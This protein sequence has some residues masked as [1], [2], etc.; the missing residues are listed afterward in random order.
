MGRS[1]PSAGA[2]RGLKGASFRARRSRSFVPGL[3]HLGLSLSCVLAVGCAPEF[4]KLE[5]RRSPRGTLGEEV[6][7]TLCRRVAGT[8]MPNDVEGRESEAICLGDAGAVA[9]ALDE[10]R[11]ALPKRVAVLAERREQFVRAVDAMLPEDTGDELEL[12]MR[13]LLPFYDAPEERVQENTRAFASVLERLAAN[14][15]ALNALTRV[16]RDGV[17]SREGSFGLYR[18]LLGYDRLN[19]LFLELLPVLSDDPNVRPYFQTML[20]GVAL[21]LA[22][23]DLDDAPDSDTRRL[24]A[25]MAREDNDF[26]SERPLFITLR[27]P[28]GLPV[29]TPREGKPVPF[30]FVDQDGD[31]LADVQDGDFVLDEGFKG[32]LPGAFATSSEQ[33]VSRDAFGRALGFLPDGS[34]ETV[35]TLFETRDID[36]T[37]LAGAFREMTALFD[38]KGKTAVHVARLVPAIFGDRTVQR[39]MY[40]KAQLDYPASDTEQSPVVDLMHASMSIFE[41]PAY[42]QSLELTHRMIDKHEAEMVHALSP[43]LRLEKRTRADSDAYPKASLAKDSVFWDELLFEAERMS[44]RRKTQDGPTL[45]ELL[46]RGA[47]GY[48]RNTSKPGAPVEQIVDPEV[49]R[50]QG[51]LIATLMRYKDEWRNNP[52]GESERDPSEPRTIGSFRTPVDRSLPDSPVTCGKD[53]CGGLIEGSPFERW[54]TPGQNCVLQ[55][56]GRPKSGKDCGAPA[57]QSVLHRSMGLIWEMAGRSQCNKSITLGDLL[58]FAVVQ[59]AC[60]KL[61]PAKT[62]DP[63]AANRDLECQGKY[64]DNADY[65]CDAATAL[66]IAKAGSDECIRLKQLQRVER[67]DTI[68]QAEERVAHDYECPKDKPGAAC[69]AYVDEFPAAFVDPDGPGVG[70]P[71]TLM[72][73]NLINLPD[74][75]RSFGRALTHEFTIEIPNPWMRRYLE[76]VARAGNESIPD[77]DDSFVITDPTL[78]PPCIPGSARLSRDVYDEMS[79]EIDTLGELIAYLLDDSSLFA[80][81]KDSEEL[82]PDVAALTRVLFAPPGSSSFLMFDP[83]LVHGSPSACVEDDPKPACLMDDTAKTPPGGCCIKNPTRP[84]FR[85]RLDTYYGTTSFAWEHPIEFDDGS[86]LSLIDAMKTLADGVN[87]TDYDAASGDDPKDFEGTDFLFSTLG[88]MVA[89]HYDSPRN[90]GVQNKDPALPHYR[91]QSN[92]VSYEE[93]LADA[94]DDGT[95]LR[96]QLAPHEGTLF[97][98]A[99]LPNKPERQLGLIYHSYPLLER[100]ATLEIGGRDGIGFSAGLAELLLSPHASCAPEGGDLRVIDGKG[101]CDMLASGARACD[102]KAP[103]AA[104]FRAPLTY[105]DGRA[106]RCWNDGTCFDTVDACQYTSPLYLA[107]DS[108]ASMDDRISSSEEFEDAFQGARAGLFDSYL[109][110]GKDA[111]ENR[112]LRAVLLAAIEEGREKWARDA[113]SGRLAQ[114]GAELV[115]DTV[116]LLQNPVFAGALG[117]IEQ[118]SPNQELMEVLNRYARS[119]L[120]G[121]RSEAQSRAMIATAGDMLELLPGD[122]ELLSLFRLMGDSILPNTGQVISEGLPFDLGKGMI[123]RNLE[124]LRDTSQKD[125]E[126]VLGRMLNNAV[127]LPGAGT[128]EE[129]HSALAQIYDVLIA[130]EREDPGAATTPSAQDFRMIFG[131]MAEILR[132]ERRGF[133]RLYEIV[134]CRNGSTEVYQCD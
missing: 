103:R 54:A 114:V 1:A 133:E 62:C 112:R 104:G 87:R 45:L 43:L 93:L 98:E 118:I 117:V 27:D 132:D 24:K 68:K 111:F 55:R 44:R 61:E 38:E 124:L 3:V 40:G 76:D 70:E 109:V 18:A 107:L 59:E 37:L 92:L 35:R 28:R 64:G 41:R 20:T 17:L 48:A 15:A 52:K 31:G 121:D 113:V 126:G 77:C 13:E 34:V 88:K 63:D 29:P 82:R 131:H 10:R 97:D 25:L 125:R 134:Q 83:L 7:K 106:T 42:D 53:G 56:D 65:V 46:L 16:A 79:P 22:T 73:C 51:A 80:T 36:R 6:Y 78:V 72:E 116:D 95:L 99:T 49:L 57:N 81:P 94:L 85:Y 66:C 129:K 120:G 12:L 127:A 11:E 32:A 5:Q 8:E 110:L 50:H 108:L 58:D 96:A 67:F 128:A 30:P 101:A 4:E 74:V 39:R 84:P 119:V 130:L 89:K 122:E 23:Q 123:W 115:T 71:A 91:S 33:G 2:R 105:R 86:R 26:A 102:G 9:E 90:P 14:D 47:L 19:G 69:L 21:E 100:L 60:T 75:G